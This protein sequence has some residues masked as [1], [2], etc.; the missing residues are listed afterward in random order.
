MKIQI[1]RVDFFFERQN[2]I[3]QS[4]INFDKIILDIYSYIAFC[5]EH[6]F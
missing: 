5:E 2:V 3:L 6:Q 1:D 4:W